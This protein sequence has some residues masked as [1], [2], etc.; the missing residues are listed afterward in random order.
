VPDTPIRGDGFTVQGLFSTRKVS[1]MQDL[2]KFGGTV[3]V[4]A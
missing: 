2:L 3:I 1:E 4:V